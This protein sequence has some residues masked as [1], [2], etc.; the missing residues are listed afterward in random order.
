MD[1]IAIFHGLFPEMFKIAFIRVIVTVIRLQL[2]IYL[3]ISSR[4][5]SNFETNA[6]ELLE[7]RDEIYVLVTGSS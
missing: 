4:C 2:L 3:D 5:S 7:N 1:Y 6:S